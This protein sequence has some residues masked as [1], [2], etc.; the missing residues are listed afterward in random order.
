[1]EEYEVGQ[2]IKGTC[3]APGNNYDMTGTIGERGRLAKSCV[4]EQRTNRRYGE[5]Y[6]G[7]EKE[8]LQG[9]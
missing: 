3:K 9:I 8:S 5:V 4:V 7:K 1:M 2:K 6:G